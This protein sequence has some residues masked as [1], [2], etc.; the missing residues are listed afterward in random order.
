M[1]TIEEIVSSETVEADRYQPLMAVTQQ[2]LECECGTLAIYV[3]LIQDDGKDKNGLCFYCQSCFEEA[4][5]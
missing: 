5:E 4:C 2:R 3:I 1:A